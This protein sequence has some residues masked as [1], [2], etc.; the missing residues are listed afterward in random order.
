MDAVECSVTSI[1]VETATAESAV[2]TAPLAVL[3][4]IYTG[5]NLSLITYIVF[6]PTFKVVIHRTCI[7]YSEIVC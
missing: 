6:Q 2:Q 5:R 1:I 7:F 3:A 4:K